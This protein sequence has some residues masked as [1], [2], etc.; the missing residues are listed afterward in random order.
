MTT[1]SPGEPSPARAR[2]LRL[3]VTA[4][5]WG[6]LAATSWLALAFTGW[7]FETQPVGQLARDAFPLAVSATTGAASVAVICWTLP[8]RRWAFSLIGVVPALLVVSAYFTTL[9]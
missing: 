7:G 6:L 8:A 1:T 3:L 5:L 4:P 9:Y 2:L